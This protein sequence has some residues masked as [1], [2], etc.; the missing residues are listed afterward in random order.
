MWHLLHCSNHHV[1]I[2]GLLRAGVYPCTFGIYV[3]K[4]CSFIALFGSGNKDA[5][6]MDEMDGAAN[7]CIGC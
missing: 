2:F 1:N 4:F 6:D 5:G 3:N 7:G